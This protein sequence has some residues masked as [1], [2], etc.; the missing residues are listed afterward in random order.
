M[1]LRCLLFG[2][3]RS[4]SRASLD[5]KRGLWVSECRRCR[6]PMVRNDDGTW[7]VTAPPTVGKLVPIESGSQASAVAGGSTGEAPAASPGAAPDSADGGD[8]ALAKDSQE[9]VEFS[10]S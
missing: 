6:V 4:R 8:S 7:H 1:T 5:E 2:H 3:I 9:P 10:A